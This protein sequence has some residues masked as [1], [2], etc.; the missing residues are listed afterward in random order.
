M[1]IIDMAEVESCTE[2]CCGTMPPP[3]SLTQYAYCEGHEQ[4]WGGTP[5]A[6]GEAFQWMIVGTPPSAVVKEFARL[7]AESA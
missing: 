4:W 1:Q 6:D 2:Q 7:R 5:S 3:T